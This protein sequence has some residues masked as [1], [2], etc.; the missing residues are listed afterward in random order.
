MHDPVTWYGINYA[1]TQ[2]TQ[3][4]VLNKRTRTSLG[5]R[6]FVFKVPL[7]N[8][9]S[10]IINSVPC[11][12]IVQRPHWCALRKPV[13]FQTEFVI[14]SANNRQMNETMPSALEKIQDKDRTR[15]RIKIQVW[16]RYRTTLCS[17]RG[18]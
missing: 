6:F 14:G 2:V 7:C 8:L 11:D 18:T 12:R 13:A 10:S 1:E 4:D 9:R 15:K 3:W 17:R 16:K 5:R